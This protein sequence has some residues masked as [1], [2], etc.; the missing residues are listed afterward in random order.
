GIIIEDMDTYKRARIL[1]DEAG[2]DY[3]EAK[4]IW[5]IDENIDVFVDM[6]SGIQYLKEVKD[7]IIQG[8]RLAVREGPLAAEP[9][10]GVKVILRDAVIHEDPAHRG[11]AQI[12]PAVRNPIFAGI[13][14][15]RPTLLEPI[16]KL[17]IKVPMDYLGPISAVITKKRG[18]ILNVVHAAGN[19]VKILCEVPVAESIDLA[20]ELRGASAGRAFWGTEFAG[21]MSVPES[22]LLDVVKRILQRK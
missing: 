14:M 11:P 6:T 19:I 8:F 13:L 12:F 7:T 3:D 18:K 5:A 17:E 9:V 21:W 4:R 2:W 20:N 22:I 16:Q 15:S 10:R 1:R